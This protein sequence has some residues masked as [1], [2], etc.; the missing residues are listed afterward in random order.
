MA[1]S[2]LGT[3]SHTLTA[4]HA[5]AHAGV[6]IAALVLNNGGAVESSAVPVG[7]TKT[8]LARFLPGI[9]IVPLGPGARADA[10]AEY[11]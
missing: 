5:L 10:L 8:S 1:G 3:I 4:A 6:E 9:A 2:Y 7:E 11:L